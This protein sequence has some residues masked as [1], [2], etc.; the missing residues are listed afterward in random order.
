MKEVAVYWHCDW[1]MGL[2]IGTK[3]PH[4][5]WFQ[6]GLKQ[7]IANDFP[8]LASWQFFDHGVSMLWELLICLT[9]DLVVVRRPKEE[10]YHH[11]GED[12]HVGIDHEVQ[13][14]LEGRL[15][16]HVEAQA[17]GTG[18][19]I[20]Q[21]SCYLMLPIVISPSL[22]SLTWWSIT[23]ICILY[24]NRLIFY[25]IMELNLKKGDY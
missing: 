17:E 21:K 23:C 4:M 10:D 6:L 13:Q 18:L 20:A 24:V 8:S 3:Y 14:T 2:K 19:T 12:V 22:G 1:S 25:L 11:P 7:I 9:F 5:D 15:P 16:F